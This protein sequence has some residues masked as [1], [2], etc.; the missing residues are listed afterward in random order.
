MSIDPS[1]VIDPGAELDE[2]VTVGPWCVIG[3]EVSIGSGTVIHSNVVIRTKTRIGRDNRFFQFSSIGE[4]P[5]DKKYAGEEAWLEIGDN[6]TFREGVTLHRGTGVGGGVTRIGNSNL[7]MCYVHIAHD[8][9]VGDNTVFANNVGISGHVE[10]ADW[11]II[12]GYSGINQ[13]LKIGAHA[14]VGGMTHI[15]KNVPA[16]II[17]SGNP[18]AVRSVN[19]VGLE[20]RGFSETSISAIRTAFKII[21]K[22]GHTTEE[23]ITQ[24]RKMC[25]EHPELQVLVDSMLNAEKGIHR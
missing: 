19:T 16:Y 17:V 22:R 11:A 23:A 6:N 21:Y 14:M 3:P 8:C 20:R 1:A 9:Q 18:A 4:D 13:F 15:A 25:G 7:I 12:G 24:V 10:V 2:G 5:A